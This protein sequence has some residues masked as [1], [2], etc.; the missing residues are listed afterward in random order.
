[1]N[2]I[3]LAELQ[4]ME[5]AGTL[6][7]EVLAALDHPEPVWV[8]ASQVGRIDTAALQLLAVLWQSARQAGKPPRLDRPS[9]EFQRVAGCLGLAG[10]FGLAGSA[11]DPP[12]R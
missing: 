1:M 8:D 10:L 4:T 9:P 6:K 5:N 7:E 12:S 11:G 2:K 3:V